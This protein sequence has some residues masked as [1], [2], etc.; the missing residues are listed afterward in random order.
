MICQIWSDTVR[1][2]KASGKTERKEKKIV[3]MIT[4]TV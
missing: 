2:F 4:N 3:M 1:W